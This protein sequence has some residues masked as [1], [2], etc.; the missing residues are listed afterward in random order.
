[1]KRTIHIVYLLIY[2]I[3]FQLQAQGQVMPL[4]CGGSKVRYGV[5]GL[6]NSVFQW[7]ITNGTIDRNY[8][9][10]IDVT[11]NSASG[12][13]TLM[14]TEHTANNCVGAPYTT[15]VNLDNLSLSLGSQI[16][17]CDGKT[18]D[19][20]SPGNFS[21]YQWSNGST[22]PSI[23]ASKQGW[24]KLKVTDSKGC[25]A[26]DSVYLAL[27][28]SP[29]VNLGN[30]TSLCNSTLTLDAGTDGTSYVWSTNE[31]T[32]RIEVTDTKSNQIFWV[33]VENDLGCET[34]D[35]IRILA[36]RGYQIEGVPNTF[37][38]NGDGFNDTWN[39]PNLIYYP[40]AS[41]EI[42]DRWGRMVFQSKHGLPNG[43]W[44]GT[45]RGRELPMDS[46]YYIINLHNGTDPMKGTV[47]IVR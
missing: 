5:T 27:L 32:S 34:S 18:T 14:V 41:V 20:A 29:K 12:T 21:S 10:S 33:K 13:G 30:D 1:M 44:D 7:T 22:D 16:T 43:G 39:I 3:S 6:P 36:C 47:T 8:N 19:I 25:S 15:S 46:Y 9:D 35:T 23:I 11:W 2:L 4:A 24:Y 40:D 26:T 17:I 38:P 37:T 42:Y 45:S 31:I 28:R